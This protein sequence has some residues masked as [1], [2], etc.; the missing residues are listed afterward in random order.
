MTP[1]ARSGPAPGSPRSPAG[2]ITRE[3]D[4]EAVDRRAVTV[5]ANRDRN[6]ELFR[7]FAPMNER[8]D[9]LCA[10]YSEAELELLVGFLR[11]IIGAGGEA[12]K[13]LAGE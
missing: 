6:A 1:T 2:W 12:T 9:V 10:D 8:M 7:L 4:P 5:R 13:E 11:R 3:R